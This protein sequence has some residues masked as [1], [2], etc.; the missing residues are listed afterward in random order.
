MDLLLL[1]D[2]LS[3]NACVSA[4]SAEKE[5]RRITVALWDP[6]FSI[7]GIQ[8]MLS[9]DLRSVVFLIRYKVMK[10]KDAVQVT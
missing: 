1:T 4:L 6:E 3:F 7:G 5:G 10:R 9:Y 2:K 8:R